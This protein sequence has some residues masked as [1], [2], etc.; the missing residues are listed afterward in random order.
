MLNIIWLSM[1]FLALICGIFTG[2]LGDVVLAVTDS[3]K[4]AFD[5]AL[6]LAAI[7]SL[8]LGIMQVATESG[9]V[10][11]L[12]R[13]LKPLMKKIFPDVPENHPAM[14]AMIMSLSAN[15]FGLG[16]AA[17]PFSLQAMKELQ[18]LNTNVHTAT[19]AMCMFVVLNAS[20]LQLIP[21]SAIAYLAMNGSHHPSAII[22]TTLLA[23]M[24]STIVAFVAAKYFSKLP[25]FQIRQEEEAL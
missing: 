12:A 18:K 9:L 8:W 1:M 14:G 11:G 2:K 7:M 5:L 4:F 21:T 20:S 15:L 16:N 22:S 17:T 3:A 6:G 13:V 10:K 25:M 23:T 19:D 24:T